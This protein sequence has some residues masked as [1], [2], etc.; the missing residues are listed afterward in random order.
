MSDES[1]KAPATSNNIFNPLL[2][3]VGTKIRLEFKGS[4]LK[5]DKVSFDYRKMVI[6]TLFLR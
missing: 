3:Y 2:N 6:V 1:I 5:H 4:C